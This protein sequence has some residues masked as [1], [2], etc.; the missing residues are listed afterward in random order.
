[1]TAHRILHFIYISVFEPDDDSNDKEYKKVHDEYKNLVSVQLCMP[2]ILNGFPCEV[3]TFRNG[4][5][6]VVPDI[7]LWINN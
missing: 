4:L 3:V 5:T 1:M 2:E 6:K 7:D